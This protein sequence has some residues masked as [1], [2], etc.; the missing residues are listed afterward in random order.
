MVVSMD[1]CNTL[2]GRKGGVDAEEAAEEEEAASLHGSGAGPGVGSLGT[3]RCHELHAMEIQR[4]QVALP[5]SP[6]G[7]LMYSQ[8]VHAVA[9]RG[10]ELLPILG[11]VGS[12]PVW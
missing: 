7:R 10:S 11:N 6:R 9:G 4:R 5:E 3:G 1:R 12:D 2:P 8:V